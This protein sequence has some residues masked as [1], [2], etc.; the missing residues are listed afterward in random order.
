MHA[1]NDDLPLVDRT[2]K[3]AAMTTHLGDVAPRMS[4]VCVDGDPA[5]TARLPINSVLIGK[6]GAVTGVEGGKKRNRLPRGMTSVRDEV[7][8]APSTARAYGRAARESGDMSFSLYLEGLRAMFE[9]ELGG[10]PVIERPVRV[11]PAEEAA[12]DAA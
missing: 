12:I 10:L 2:S 6:I 9:A 11:A 3:R 1:L 4:S 7:R 5:S 8:L